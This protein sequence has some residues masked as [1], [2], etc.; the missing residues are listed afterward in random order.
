MP[1]SGSR[2]AALPIRWRSALSQVKTSR[3]A[4]VAPD[5]S[6]VH[7]HLCSW[8]PRGVPRVI[9]DLAI[10]GG[11]IFEVRVIAEA[12]ELASMKVELVGEGS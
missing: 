3:T 5:A 1:P 2:Q 6:T 10:A 12:G 11:K 8:A 7:S 4:P 9:L